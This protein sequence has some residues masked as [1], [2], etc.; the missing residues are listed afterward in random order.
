MFAS[1]SAN[2]PPRYG[3]IA[4]YQPL[5]TFQPFITGLLQIKH[6]YVVRIRRNGGEKTNEE[7]KKEKEDHHQ[8][9]KQ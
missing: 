1:A 3:I 8:L 2:S 7:E 5:D 6:R 9:L 4:I